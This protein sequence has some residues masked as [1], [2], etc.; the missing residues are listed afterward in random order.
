MVVAIPVTHMTTEEMIK[1]LERMYV[2]KEGTLKCI[3][4]E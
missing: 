1:Q 2:K 3:S 4:L